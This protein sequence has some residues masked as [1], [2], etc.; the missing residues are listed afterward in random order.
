MNDLNVM[1]DLLK[2]WFSQELYRLDKTIK[3]MNKLLF[4]IKWQNKT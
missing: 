2:V 3:Q 1:L 4:F